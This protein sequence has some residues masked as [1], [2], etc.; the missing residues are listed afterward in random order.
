VL[1]EFDLP[2]DNLPSP[3]AEFM[4]PLLGHAHQ[5]GN[6]S[7]KERIRAKA[8]TWIM[9]ENARREYL[10][11]LV[12]LFDLSQSLKNSSTLLICRKTSGLAFLTQICL[13][14]K[15]DNQVE[16]LVQLIR[17]LVVLP[18]W[19]D[20]LAKEKNLFWKRQL[21]ALTLSSIFTSTSD[22]SENCITSNDTCYLASR[23]QDQVNLRRDSF[24]TVGQILD[25]VTSNEVQDKEE[26]CQ[27]FIPQMLKGKGPC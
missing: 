5:C 24:E 18:L 3:W 7:T 25:L 22:D 12:H 21:Q 11:W 15:Q 19:R 8:K 6:E 27:K 17:S 13:G 10:I 14:K 2:K 23:T 20:P 4:L 16:Y 9:T 1:D 26:L